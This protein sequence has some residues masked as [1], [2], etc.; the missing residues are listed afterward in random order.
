MYDVSKTTPKK[1]PP[2]LNIPRGESVSTSREGSVA[3]AP[4]ETGDAGHAAY[5]ASLAPVGDP[6]DPYART[7]RPPQNRNLDSIDARFVFQQKERP[8]SLFG[9]TPSSPR[10]SVYS[11]DTEKKSSVSSIKKE[12]GENKSH[13]GSMSD[14]KRFL[15]IGGTKREKTEKSGPKSKKSKSGTSTP[16]SRSASTTAMPFGDDHGLEGR[17]GRFERMLGSGAGG[18]V[19]LM[20][21]ADGVTFAVKQFRDRH[22]WETERAYNKKITAE[23]CVGSTLHHGN[24]IEALDIVNENTKWYEVME[25]APYDLFNIVMSGKMSREEV[26]CCTMQIINGVSYLHSMGLAHRD[27]KLDN[28]VV[29]EHGIL[30]IIDFGSAH[31]FQYP[32]EKTQV[33]AE[34]MSCVPD[35]NHAKVPGVVGSDPYLAPEVFSQK[36]Y[37]AQLVDV[38]SLAIIFCCMTLRRFPWKCP[39]PSDNSYK[40]FTTQ[41]TEDELRSSVYP[42]QRL[43]SV[44]QS[45]PAS[46][47]PSEHHHHHHH[48]RQGQGQASS[49]PEASAAAPATGGDGPAPAA[50]EDPVAGLPAAG[51]AA[52]STMSL[53]SAASAPQPAAPA[54][55]KGPWRLLRLL[56]RET[57]SIVGRMLDVDPERRASLADVTADAWICRTPFCRQEVGG[58]VVWA[59]GHSH[60]LRGGGDEAAE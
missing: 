52:A 7:R 5:P 35:N 32:F 17:Y 38:W 33:L 6:N 58:R 13:H 42:Q 50:D 47:A 22:A 31:V 16:P 1:P 34:G 41:P 9:G 53:S 37:D 44:S 2:S 54:V 18:S 56:P 11:A 19:R 57:R 8:R 55:I 46:R 51:V 59:D 40:L 3:S 49:A 15:K 45:E 24:V 60:V 36:K 23:F 39:K 25:Y 29:N 30:K 21:R 12:H 43:P 26:A 10:A 14:L 20:K 27:L 48:S 4:R 28:V